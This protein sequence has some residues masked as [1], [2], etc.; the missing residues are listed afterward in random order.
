MGSNTGVKLV[1]AASV[2]IEFLYQGVRCRERVKFN[3]ATTEPDVAL[4]KAYQHRQA[5]LHAIDNGSFD[6]A[7]VFPTSR[8]V[9]KFTVEK[10]LTVGVWLDQWLAEKEP[11]LKT[12]TGVGYIARVNILKAHFGEIKLTDLKKTDVKAWC[13]T[14]TCSNKTIANLLSPFRVALQEAYSD[15]LVP[16][17]ILLNFRFRRNVPPPARSVNPF[18][19]EEQEIILA[20]LS[21]Q[22]RNLIQFAFWTGLRTSELVALEWQ[23]IDWDRGIIQIRR[24]KTQHARTPE[25]TK[26]RAGD[27]EVK[28]L[29][30]AIDALNAQRLIAP[31][32]R[33]VIFADPLTGKPWEGDQPINRLWV[34]TL[35]IAGVKYRKPYS[36]RHTYASMMLSA[37]ENLAWVSRQLGHSSVIQTA[38]TY[39][40][41]MPNSQPEAGGKA[42]EIFSTKKR[43]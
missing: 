3:P 6:Y 8:N 5:I 40:T 4:K 36:T 29:P 39:A 12:S 1:T 17:N 28:L 23:D 37:G 18:S 11:H 22:P 25:T 38:G 43:P 21:E 41:W 9:K 14:L 35:K 16:E 20:A 31:E 34:K 30:P 10:C 15:S 33:N 26:T 24:G 19:P 13:K 32:S 2:Q 27:R 42:V 7:T